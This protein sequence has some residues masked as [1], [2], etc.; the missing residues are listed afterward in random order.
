[1][2]IYKETEKISSQVPK[3]QGD[4]IQLE[5]PDSYDGPVF[6][7]VINADCDLEHRKNDN[8]IA[9]I[10]IYSFHDYLSKFW[11][12]GHIDEVLKKATD[13]IL[14]ITGD[15]DQEALYLWLQSSSLDVVTSSLLTSLK[16]KKKEIERFKDELRKISICRDEN[17]RPIDRFKQLCAIAPNPKKYAQVYILAAKKAMGEGH[18]F[19]SDFLDQNNI[20]YVVRMRRIYI[21]QE[22]DYFLSISDQK[23]HS[24]GNRLT[25]VRV[26]RLTALHRFKIIQLFAQQYSRVG[27]PDEL[28]ELED[29]ALED[30]I[31]HFSGV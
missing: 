4:I 2:H 27:L 19:I 18:F 6:G 16:L 7:I 25:G 14:S 5:W 15:Q 1:M 24:Q 22:Q 9:F 10:P 20:G 17:Y 12:S 28:T 31:E 8:V 3:A 30:I 11:A 13:F 23:A 21:L 26:G 29:L